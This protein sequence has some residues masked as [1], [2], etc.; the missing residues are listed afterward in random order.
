MGIIGEFESPCINIIALSSKDFPIRKGD[1]VRFIPLFLMMWLIFC[2]CGSIKKT[3][4]LERDSYRLIS[5]QL[6]SEEL[7]AFDRDI[8]LIFANYKRLFRKRNHELA[9]LTIFLDWE[10]RV[11]GADEF[12]ALYQ[13]TTQSIRFHRKP[14]LMLLLHEIAHHFIENSGVETKVWMNEGL[15]TYLGWSALDGERII[16]GEIPVVHYKTMKGLIKE[17]HITPLA[18]FIELEQSQFYDEVKNN[19]NYTQ[20][21]GLIFYL[22]NA[23]FQSNLSFYEKFNKMLSMTPEQIAKADQGFREFWEGFSAVELMTKRL[24]SAVYLRRLSSAFRLGLMQDEAGIQ[25]LVDVAMNR[26]KDVRFRVVSLYALS[27]IALGS[28]KNNVKLDLMATLRVLRNHVSPRV[29]ECA[30]ELYDAVKNNHK[31]KIT[32]KFA[33]IGHI[34]GF[35]P[36]GRFTV[37]QEDP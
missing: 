20:A 25:P 30:S 3:H 34:G 24:R 2:S 13:K 26:M 15:A 27:M 11:F 6:V 7:E 31:K 32:D 9:P 1:L 21:W 28:G 16:T 36:A 5:S 17:G 33:E 29:K 18:E 4:I 19:S 35:Y 37:I 22:F 10:T 23:Y 14:D 12:P 8:G